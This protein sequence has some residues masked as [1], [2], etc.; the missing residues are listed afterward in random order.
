[1]NIINPQNPG[2]F[3]D[4]SSELKSAQTDDTKSLAREPVTDEEVEVNRLKFL[5]ERERSRRQD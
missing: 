3:E 1:M 5:R 4:D 2:L